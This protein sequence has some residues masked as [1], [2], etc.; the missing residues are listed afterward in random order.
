MEP[1]ANL[2][3]PNLPPSAASAPVLT[4]PPLPPEQP[5]AEPDKP[6]AD[7]KVVERAKQ[8]W[9]YGIG[10]E[11]ENRKNFRDDLRFAW[12][13]GGQWDEADR[14][15]RDLD[16]RPWLEFNQTGQ[17][18]KQVAN[19]IRQNRMA[20]TVRP[21]SS[22]ATAQ[23][24][25]LISDL[26]RKIQYGSNAT[27]IYNAASEQAITG[28]FGFWR[29][30]SE[31]ERADSFNQRLRILPISNALNAVLD[32][33]AQ[34]PDKSDAQWGFVMDWLD[35]D[36]ME[37]EWGD[38]AQLV[39]WD[40]QGEWADWYASDK[41][42]VADYYE[43]VHEDDTLLLLADG[44]TVWAS[45]V[46]VGFPV[47]V[48]DKRE[49]KRTRCKWYKLTASPEPLAVYDTPFEYIP[50]VMVVGDEMN[51]DGKTIRRGMVRNL[52]DPAKLFNYLFTEAAVNVKSNGNAPWLMLN[53]QDEGHPEWND[54]NVET[55]AK[56]TYEAV[57]L[58]D[59]TC[60]TGPPQRNVSAPVP[61][62]L[63]Q[64]C[65]MSQNLFREITGIKDPALGNHTQEQSGV[66]ILARDRISDTA[67]FHHIDNL[68]LAIEHTGRIIVNAVPR[69]YG[70]DRTLAL[71]KQDGTQYT[72]RVNVATGV[73]G[74][75]ALNDLKRGVYSVCVDVGPSYQ[76][77]RLEAAN[78]VTEFLNVVDPTQRPLI[79][80]LAASMIDAPD[81]LGDRMAARLFASLP[82]QVQQADLQDSDDPKIK[83]LLGAMQ[84]QS[85]QFQQQ[86]Q[87]MGQ[88]MQD[89]QTTNTQL[90]TLLMN[91]TAEANAKAEAERTR[92]AEVNARLSHDQFADKLDAIVKLLTSP[93]TNPAAAAA[94]PQAAGEVNAAASTL[95][96][97]A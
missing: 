15:K 88:Q 34:E 20:I 39:S 12:E 61:A 48:K 42:A 28:G 29:I 51:V 59:G 78:K 66:A 72:K 2:P 7:P 79:T 32:P 50:I 5:G 91:K 97:A 83:A 53:G 19:D 80:D 89:L 4:Q 65:T 56:L 3:D 25:T 24:A 18:V 43:L 22:G 11:D 21:E 10:V 64:M 41:V 63:V 36:A 45:D 81:N 69:V 33:D 67:T 55:Y 86:M 95:E 35:R 1:S 13:R 90:E 27:A 54:A 46:K 60:F 52:R 93:A 84:Q 9:K 49:G 57:K 92:Q 68:K 62:G 85:M 38:Q 26:V 74:V 44:S 75:Q 70:N 16:R 8:R 77:E 6:K 14:R 23:S 76:T 47:A 87:Q 82:P 31:W 58:P 73:D 37:R 71:M 17:F 40:A 30:V 96:G 94:A